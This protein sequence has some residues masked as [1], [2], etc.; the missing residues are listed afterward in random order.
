MLRSQNTMNAHSTLMG[1]ASYGS[2][3]VPYVEK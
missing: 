3:V 2:V 1:E